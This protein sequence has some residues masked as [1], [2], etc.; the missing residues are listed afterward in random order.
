LFG[1]LL[2]RIEIA[3]QKGLLEEHLK[4]QVERISIVTGVFTMYGWGAFIDRVALGDEYVGVSWVNIKTVRT[5]EDKSVRVIFVVGLTP[6]LEANVYSYS[7]IMGFTPKVENFLSGKWDDNVVVKISK[8][9][10]EKIDKFL[11][12]KLIPPNNGGRD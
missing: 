10:K 1:G 4:F 11:L 9:L 6:S 3:W 7:P 5:F 12:A 2:L 8:K